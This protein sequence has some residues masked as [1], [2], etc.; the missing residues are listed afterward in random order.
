MTKTPIRKGYY[1]GTGYMGWVEALGRYVLF[2]TEAEYE[3]Y[4]LS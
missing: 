3:D 2:A 1:V 4:I